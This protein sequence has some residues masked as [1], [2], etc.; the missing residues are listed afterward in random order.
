MGG[1]EL[2]IHR[3]QRV[4]AELLH[5]VVEPFL[6]GAEALDGAVAVPGP[7]TRRFAGNRLRPVLPVAGSPHRAPRRELPRHRMPGSPRAAAT[8]S[9]YQRS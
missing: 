3:A 2:G 9:P 7:C 6:V 8:S 4:D 5:P 1:V